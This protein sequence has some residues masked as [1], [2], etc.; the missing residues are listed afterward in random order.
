LPSSSGLLG[1]WGTDSPSPTS[2]ASLAVGSAADRLAC[3]CTSEDGVLKGRPTA[4]ERLGYTSHNRNRS[5]SVANA[6]APV[7]DPFV[8]RCLL[9]SSCV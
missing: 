1:S 6:I 4:R 5:H 3:P 7:S 2:R 8:S 9:L